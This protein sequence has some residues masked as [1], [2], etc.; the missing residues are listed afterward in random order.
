[1]QMRHM[2]VPVVKISDAAIV[3]I[4]I[5][6]NAGRPGG[7]RNRSMLEVGQTKPAQQI[8]GAAEQ[9]DNTQNPLETP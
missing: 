5:S 8:Q 9:H 2:R 6:V 4:K 1:M 7:R 3:Y